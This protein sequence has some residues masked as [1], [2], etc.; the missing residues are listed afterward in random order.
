MGMDG[1]CSHGIENHESLMRRV[2]VGI[3]L[4]GDAGTVFE[5]DRR[6][7]AY[8][9]ERSPEVQTG[10]ARYDGRAAFGYEPVDLPVG[11][12]RERADAHLLSQRADTDQPRR[13]RRLVRQYRQASVD[14]H[15][16]RRDDFRAEPVGHSLRYGALPRRC[17]PEDRN[18]LGAAPGIHG[19]VDERGLAGVT[20]GRRPAVEP[21]RLGALL[22]AR[23]LGRRVGPRALSP[24]DL[25][26]SAV[27]RATVLLPTHRA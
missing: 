4:S 12:H 15:G 19:V 9:G 8:V 22:A 5:G 24:R 16:I 18:D 1:P 26:V 20:D 3:D 2:A 10:S 6:R 23:H 27:T 25:S 13:A 11:E 14:L 17:R 21:G 7:D